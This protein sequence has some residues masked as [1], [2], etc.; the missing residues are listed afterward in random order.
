MKFILVKQD[1]SEIPNFDAQ[2]AR[3]VIIEENKFK[4][5]WL[6]GV[7]TNDIIVVVMDVKVNSR[8][9]GEDGR[10]TK[11]LDNLRH[12]KNVFLLTVGKRD[13]TVNEV[14]EFVTK[15]FVYERLGNRE[16]ELSAKLELAALKV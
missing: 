10:Y 5:E 11:L 12:F 8:V 1:L 2:E 9:L 13:A 7:G 14:P 15:T 4:S 16:T 6:S 3:K